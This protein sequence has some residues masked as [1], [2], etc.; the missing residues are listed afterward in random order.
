MVVKLGAG[1]LGTLKSKA[2][3][4]MAVGLFSWGYP[5]TETAESSVTLLL[6]SATYGMITIAPKAN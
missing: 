5:E 4:D 6:K 2:Y 1:H 3:R